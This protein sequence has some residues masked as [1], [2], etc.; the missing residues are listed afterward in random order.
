M[1]ITDDILFATIDSLP[2]LDKKSATSDILAIPDQYSFWDTYR[3]TKMFPM[4]T[5]NGEA[6]RSGTSNSQEGNFSWT[7]SAPSS[8]V[9][10]CEDYLF[11][12]LGSKTRVMC[13]I[14]KP[15]AANY[16]H[17]DC[18]KH[19]LNTRQHKVRLVL[20]GNTDTL[21]WM[22][23]DGNVRAPAVDK[24]FLMDGGWPHGM[25][26]SDSQP[27][28]TLALGAP[29]TGKD[30]YDDITILQRRSAFKMPSDIEHLWIKNRTK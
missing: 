22:T 23:N 29:W 2:L 17:I 11:P 13:L 25:I 16:E 20:Q 12:W 10:W 8:I 27:K 3:N 6:T 26:N 5:K 18:S 1:D 24:P 19:E 7:I 30:H 14:T 9:N 28:V 15:G 4:M 21:Y